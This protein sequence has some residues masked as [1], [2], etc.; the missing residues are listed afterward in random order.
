MDGNVSVYPGLKSQSAEEAQEAIQAAFLRFQSED[1][2]N[3]LKSAVSAASDFVMA[4]KD[5]RRTGGLLVRGEPIV[6]L[7]LLAQVTGDTVSRFQK[8]QNIANAHR[9]IFANALSIVLLELEEA[10]VFPDYFLAEADAIVFDP[11]MEELL[12]EFE[13]RRQ[14]DKLDARM[15]LKAVAA[16]FYATADSKA[17]AKTRDEKMVLLATLGLVTGTYV[18]GEGYMFRAGPV[19]QATVTQVVEPFLAAHG[20]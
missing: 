14:S 16:R 8:G 6:D 20:L 19:L 9:R 3:N 4:N 15:S 13:H 18:E 10:E 1:V 17:S 7:D 2:Q 12:R 11:K 5:R